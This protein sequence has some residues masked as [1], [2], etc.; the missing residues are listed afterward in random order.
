MT[1]DG[2]VCDPPRPAGRLSGSDGVARSAAA[3]RRHPRRA[4]ADARR[5]RRRARRGAS[6]SCC[7]WS[8]CSPSTRI[9]IRRRSRAGSASAS[10]S[11]ARWRSSRR[12]SC[13]TSR[14]RRSTSRSAPASSTC[15]SS[16]KAELGLS[17]LFV[18]H[19]LSVVRHIADRVA[20]MY[21]GPH[22]GDR[23]RRRGVRSAGASVHAGAAVG[24]SA[25]GSAEGAAAAADR[26]AGR[27]AE[28]GRSA[29]GLPVPHALSE[30]RARAGRRA[31]ARCASTSR[32]RL[33]AAHRRRRI[34]WTRATTRRRLGAVMHAAD[35]GGWIVETQSHR[36]S[37]LQA[38]FHRSTL[39]SAAI[40]LM[41]ARPRPRRYAR[42]GG[43]DRRRAALRTTPPP[44]ERI[45]STR[46]RATRCRTAARSPGRSTQMP[47]NFNYN[48]LD[49]TEQAT[50]R[51]CMLALMPDDLHERCGRHADLEPGLPG[52]RAD[53]DAPSRN[54]S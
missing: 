52:V 40:G 18:A 50:T 30:I 26:A 36:R 11:R 21:L 43:D 3:D 17:Y 10:A 8:A 34:I 54:R 16:S 2:A 9:G 46:C 19:D 5:A 31:A 22:R 32:R 24:D 37:I 39:G 14:C 23:R 4:A 13:S 45:R 35:R 1:R 7:S 44:T 12:C 49:G 27:P 42:G 25:A 29:V 33:I 53:A 20:V 28:P 6:A 38:A 41:A 15:S 51:T 48:Q 47:A